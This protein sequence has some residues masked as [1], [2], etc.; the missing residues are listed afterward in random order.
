L[1]E[2]LQRFKDFYE[3]QTIADDIVNVDLRY[4]NGI[5]IKRLEKNP[6][7]LAT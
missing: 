1:V 3:R 4:G 6:T 2:R 7:E 5:A